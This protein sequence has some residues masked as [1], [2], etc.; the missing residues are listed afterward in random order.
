MKSKYLLFTAICAFLLFALLAVTA[1]QPVSSHLVYASNGASNSMREQTASSVRDPAQIS[2]NQSS[3]IANAQANNN[4]LLAQITQIDLNP[5]NP[6]LTIC[7]DIPSVADWLPR[8]SAAYKETNYEM[9]DWILLDPENNAYIKN[10]RCYFV[11][12]PPIQLTTGKLKISLDYFEASTPERLPEDLITKVKN[13]L[14]SK[15]L[16]LDFEMKNVEHGQMIVIT[17]KPL[18]YDET[19][20]YQII[21]AAI[22]D[23]P[24]KVHGPWAFMIDV[25]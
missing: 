15:G 17:R 21:Q 8:F 7:A 13:N 2:V 5:E 24:E 4:G 14:K 1:W 16:D 22:K 25:P 23:A 19:Q 11:T 3:S 6:N 10:N 18:Q 9:L 20:A 12:L